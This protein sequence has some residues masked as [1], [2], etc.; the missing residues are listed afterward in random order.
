[1]I[2]ERERHKMASFPFHVS[3]LVNQ[4]GLTVIHSVINCETSGFDL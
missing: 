1:M 2:T 3:A 4:V